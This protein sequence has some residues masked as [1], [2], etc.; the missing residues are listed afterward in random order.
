M[1]NN[2][3]A[4][5]SFI[6]FCDDMMIAEESMEIAC[7]TTMVELVSSLITTA[8]LIAGGVA[9]LMHKKHM[10]DVRTAIALYEQN[11]QDVKKM[12]EL[13][14]KSFKIKAFTTDER[15]KEITGKIRKWMADR[16]NR[17]IQAYYDDNGNELF[18]L[19]FTDKS[20]SSKLTGKVEYELYAANDSIKKHAY[21]Y[22]AIG[23]VS[24]SLSSDKV[25]IWAKKYLQDNNY[26]NSALDYVAEFK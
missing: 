19:V 25:N 6:S 8:S 16:S 21:Y 12:G 1:N 13:K 2:T 9:V 17:V 14:T 10:K 24:R 23:C 4:I 3:F 20:M 11:N 18:Y 15:G 7:E 26:K 5:E 22:M